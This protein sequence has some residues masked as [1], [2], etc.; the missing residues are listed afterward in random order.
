MTTRAQQF[1][2]LHGDFLLVPCAWDAGSAVLMERAGATVIGTTSAGMSWSLGRP[3]GAMTA[4]LLLTAVEAIAAVTDALLT[5]DIEGGYSEDVRG[6]IDLVESLAA[7]GVVGVN[8]EDSTTAGQLPCEEAAER[9]AAVRAGLEARGRY[10]FVNTRIYSWL[11][12]GDDL[13]DMVVRARAYVRAGADGV[14]VPAVPSPSEAGRVVNAVPV[15]VNVMSD[16]TTTHETWRDLGVRRI[17]SGMALAQACY[18]GVAPAWLTW[19]TGT[20]DA[21]SIGF[22]DMQ[23]LLAARPPH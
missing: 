14:F 5:V 8:L 20:S 17:S 2:S 6:V 15:P 19:G 1:R 16:G 10:V 23:A 13:E 22:A 18:A 7:L 3:D 11:L 4:D 9:L 12:G 21:R